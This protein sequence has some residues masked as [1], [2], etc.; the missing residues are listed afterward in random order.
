MYYQNYANDGQGAKVGVLMTNLGTPDAPTREALKPYLKEFL[1]DTR[2]VE[3]PPSR[4]VWQLILN[5]IILN[6]RPQQSAEAYQTVWNTEGPGAP[7]LNISRRQLSGI[8][9]KVAD[10]FEGE[11]VFEL[12]MR[13]GN[14]SIASGLRSLQ[15]QGCG[16][17][18]ILPLYPQYAG[19]TTASTFDAV[20]DELK[21]WR[22]LPELRTIS[23]YYH[24]PGYIEALAQSIR[25]FQ[26]K[27]GSAELLVFSYHGIPVRYWENGDPYP[28]Q[29]FRTTHL[30]AEALGLKEEQVRTTFQSRFG[31]EPWVQP[32]TDET[33]KALPKEGVK[34]VQVICPGFSADCLE[35][36]EEIGE[37]NRAYFLKAGGESFGYIPCLN[38]REDHLS[39][40]ADL[41]C[42]HL[43]G[44]ENEVS[45]LG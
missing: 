9:Q 16:K 28:E 6:R 11:L 33:M 13:Y 45:G 7:L 44:W 43:Q 42:Q 23:H 31:K 37:E 34:R 20:F 32:Y 18:L 8:V 41:V 19:A 2:V 17:I 26:A 40:L 39:A 30:V 22:W 1:S 15:K 36:I 12:G 38:D 5:G 27:Y 25:D 35:T 21:T 24:H 29:C 10:Q 3:P 14:P 4:L